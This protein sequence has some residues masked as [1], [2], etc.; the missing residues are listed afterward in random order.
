MSSVCS[1]LSRSPDEQIA[2]G[3]YLSEN[4]NDYESINAITRHCTM[5]MDNLDGF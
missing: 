1:E 5:R 3:L 4:A 2:D